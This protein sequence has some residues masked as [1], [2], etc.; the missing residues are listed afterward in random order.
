MC[1]LNEVFEYSEAEHRH[2]L[3]HPG[4]RALDRGG[5]SEEGGRAVTG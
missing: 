5:G 1:D 3:R 4:L 2:G